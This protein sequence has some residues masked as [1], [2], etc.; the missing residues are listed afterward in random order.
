MRE[1]CAL[2]KHGVKPSASMFAGSD[3]ASAREALVM[4]DS[5]SRAGAA[6]R[7]RAGTR[8]GGAVARSNNDIVASSGEGEN[9]TTGNVRG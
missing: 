9:W 5:G 6:A 8:A 2:V 3:A 4:S 7:P 1:F